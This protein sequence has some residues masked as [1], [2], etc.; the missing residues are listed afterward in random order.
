MS[1]GLPCPLFP[2][3]HFHTGITNGAKWYTVTGGMQD[4]NYLRAGCMELTL[5][6][7]CVKYPNATDL[8][9]YWLDNRDALITYIEQAIFNNLLPFLLFYQIIVIFKVHKG[10][11]GFITSTIG[12]PIAN[13][14]IIIEGIPHNVKSAAAGDYWRILLPGKYNLTVEAAGYESYTKEIVNIYLLII[15]FFIILFYLN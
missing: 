14:S 11:Y 8:R 10:V 7:G 13:A 3:E 5:E 12:H 9:Q 6:L 1:L 2:L 15:S 4:W